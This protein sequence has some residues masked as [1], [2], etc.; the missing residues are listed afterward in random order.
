[1]PFWRPRGCVL[2]LDFLEPKG[3]TAYDKSGYGNHGTIYGATRVR[4]LGRYGLEF[5]GVDDYVKVPHS[6]VLNVQ[7]VTAEALIKKPFTGDHDFIVHKNPTGYGHNDPFSFYVIPAGEII[8]RIAD[9]ATAYT[10]AG[11]Y[12][13]DERWYHIVGTYDGSVMKLYVN[14]KL[15]K[16]V[17]IAIVLTTNTADL[18]I[19]TWTNLLIHWF[20]GIISFNRIYN[21]ALSEREI[22]ANHA[23]FFS[24]IKRAV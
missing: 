24:R 13:S 10:I 2:W 20:K 5:D 14:G 19:G 17:S 22:R 23:Y 4:A 1:V 18:H 3:D 11:P 12:V 15:I 21:R 9:G 8:F 16:E 6:A 7:R